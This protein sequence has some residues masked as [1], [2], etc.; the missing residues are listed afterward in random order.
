MR[1]YAIDPEGFER[2]GRAARQEFI[3]SLLRI[4][5]AVRTA[6]RTLAQ[7]LSNVNW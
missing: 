1:A 3:E 6:Q 5:A 2:R 4:R 7:K